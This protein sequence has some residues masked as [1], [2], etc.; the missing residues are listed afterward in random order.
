[1]CVLE[2]IPSFESQKGIIIEQCSFEFEHKKGAVA[3]QSLW[4]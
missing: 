4:Q 2:I 1:M 3:V